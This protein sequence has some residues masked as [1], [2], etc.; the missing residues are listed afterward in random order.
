MNHG[1]QLACSA[2]VCSRTWSVFFT[3]GGKRENFSKTSTPWAFGSRDL[4]RIYFLSF[5]FSGV[6]AFCWNFVGCALRQLFHKR[7]L[8]ISHRPFI[9]ESCNSCGMD[10]QFVH[11]QV[12]NVNISAKRGHPSF[13]TIHMILY[14]FFFSNLYWRL[15]TMGREQGTDKQSQHLGQ[16]IS[17]TGPQGGELGPPSCRTS[18]HADVCV[19]TPQSHLK[20]DIVI[21]SDTSQSQCT[22]NTAIQER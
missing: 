21:H 9:V 6:C 19:F 13:Q 10:Q 18:R 5:F 20:L 22:A 7:C 12:E 14:K 4:H 1:Y 17:K 15:I 16:N 8:F 2:E 3:K 11:V